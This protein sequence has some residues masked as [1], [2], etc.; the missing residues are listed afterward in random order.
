[1]KD[2]KEF[3]NESGDNK[4]KIKK[5][6]ELAVK[7]MADVKESIKLHASMYPSDSDDLM[8]YYQDFENRLTDFYSPIKFKK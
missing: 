2:F 6:R 5:L 7:G 4:E 8:E 1:M 3:C